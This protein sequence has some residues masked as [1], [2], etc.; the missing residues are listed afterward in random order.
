MK[1]KLELELTEEQLD[2]LYYHFTLEEIKKN[3][4]EELENWLCE[5][6]IIYQAEI[7]KIILD[8][9]NKKLLTKN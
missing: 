2:L 5:N 8:K 4:Y 9:K 1:I 3:N 7:K 6:D